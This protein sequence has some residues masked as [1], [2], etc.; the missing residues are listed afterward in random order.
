MRG[1]DMTDAMTR[2][3][4]AGLRVERLVRRDGHESFSQGHVH[5]H[6]DRNSALQ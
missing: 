3:P 5:A 1:S 2:A 4:A 6:Y